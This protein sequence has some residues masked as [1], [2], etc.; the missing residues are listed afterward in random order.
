MATRVLL[1]V[2]TELSWS[3]H[4]RGASWQENV[5]LSYDP[6][7]VG[8]RHQL[9]RLAAHGLKAC[10]FVDPMPAL[11][12]GLDPIRRMVEPILAA[13][14]EVQLHLHPCWA[15][16]SN[17]VFELI[18]H[19]PPGQL[20]LIRTARDLLV[21]AGAPSP[22]AFRS[23]S[24]AADLDTLKAL[25]ALGI[26]YD[27]S[28]NGSYH[29]SPSALPLEPRRMAPAA[30]GGVIEVPIT[31]IEQRPGRLR[32]LQICAVSF[33]E[34][35]AALL[36]AARHAHP[37]VTIVGHSFELAARGGKRANP[38]LVR[39]FDKLCG[40]LAEQGERLPTAHFTDLG[41]LRLDAE[42]APLRSHALRTAARMAEQALG[43]A[44]YER[45]F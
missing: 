17:P 30:V 26:G 2:D 36:H 33:A 4:V 13:G 16:P 32:H 18:E 22:V 39:R 25:A 24:Y 14:Q 35:R 11:V 37:V 5:A 9:A 20:E 31:Q 10:F 12:Y 41:D 19:D 21:E 23:G 28:H 27:S 44:L 43:N 29:P 38:L 6:A 8:T 34:L 15:D 1:T 42:A 7:G 3:G 40:F 45:V